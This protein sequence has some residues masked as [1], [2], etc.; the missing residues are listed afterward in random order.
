MYL[1]LAI[2]IAIKP[3][4]MMDVRSEIKLKE[5]A[6][7]SVDYDCGCHARKNENDVYYIDVFCDEHDPSIDHGNGSEE[8]E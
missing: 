4:E 6:D 8:E 2:V 1:R 3:K 7:V 5:I